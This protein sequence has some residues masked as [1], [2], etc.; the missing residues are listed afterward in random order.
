HTGATIENAFSGRSN[1]W[2]ADAIYKWAPGGNATQTNLKLQAEYFRRNERGALSYDSGGQSAGA[3][4]SA[5]DAVQSGW[6]AQGIYQF[7][8]QWRFGL[9]YDK[10]YSGTPRIAAIDDG[11]LSITDFARLLAYNPS[12]STAM[13]DYSPSEFS[14]FRVQWARDSARPGVVDNQLFIQYIMSLGVHGAHAF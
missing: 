13:V 14:R 7:I 6:Y 8:P 12:R 3:V 2:I 10:L 4:A 5:Y 1:T 9:R 11:V